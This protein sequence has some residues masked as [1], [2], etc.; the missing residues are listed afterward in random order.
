VAYDDGEA[1]AQLTVVDY[2]QEPILFNDVETSTP[3]LSARIIEEPH[4]YVGGWTYVFEASVDGG[5]LSSGT[6]LAK[7]VLRTNDPNQPEIV[8]PVEITK[9]ARV[10]VTPASVLLSKPNSGRMRTV[11]VIVRD[12]E[13]ENIT[14]GSIQCPSKLVKWTIETADNVPSGQ[15][16]IGLS[17]S[18]NGI[19]GGEVLSTEL[20]IQIREPCVQQLVVGVTALP[21]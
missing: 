13:G 7:I 1:K 20:R 2:R 5:D 9:L 4:A 18:E 16:T 14:F 6:Q 21:Q 3:I 17:L 15:R 10:V 8:I 12:R 11:P 19:A